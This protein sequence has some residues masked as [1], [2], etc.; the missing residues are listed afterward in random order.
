MPAAPLPASPTRPLQLHYTWASRLVWPNGTDAWRFN[1][2]EYLSPEL[3]DTVGACL[4]TAGA[5]HGQ[6]STAQL[7]VQ[8]GGRQRVQLG[9]HM[10]PWASFQHRSRTCAQMPTI[11]LPPPYQEGWTTPTAAAPEGRPVTRALHDVIRLLVE[12]MNAGIQEVG[13]ARWRT[14]LDGGGARPW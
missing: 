12:T 14:V 10:G 4:A 5:E 9:V 2:R 13:G 1:K 3:L 6:C 11:P 8:R 7:H